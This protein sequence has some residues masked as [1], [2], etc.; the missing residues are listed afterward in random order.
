MDPGVN[1]RHGGYAPWLSNTR[2]LE[3]DPC[4]MHKTTNGTSGEAGLRSNSISETE[5]TRTKVDS[6]ANRTY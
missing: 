1:L 5:A 2:L 6:F 4:H 3:R